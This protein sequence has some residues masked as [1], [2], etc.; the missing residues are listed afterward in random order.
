M[1]YQALLLVIVNRRE[2]GVVIEMLGRIQD[3]IRSVEL[4]E[5]NCLA[6]EEAKSDATG[7][8]LKKLAKRSVGKRAVLKEACVKLTDQLL[9]IFTGEPH[10][11]QDES[12]LV[13][14]AESFS[15]EMEKKVKSSNQQTV[16]GSG[17]GHSYT[18]EMLPISRA[19]FTYFDSECIVR[20][21]A[22]PIEDNKSILVPTLSLSFSN[23][24]TEIKKLSDKL[25][26]YLKEVLGTYSIGVRIG[27]YSR[28]KLGFRSY[29][30]KYSVVSQ[31]FELTDFTT[32]KPLGEFDRLGK[33]LYEIEVDSQ[34]R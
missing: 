25:G 23:T 24:D 3:S 18:D 5:Y 4:A 33:L 29:L 30:A 26:P 8:L 10:W 11:H 13:Y 20:W 16:N 14:I 17:C 15:K 32:K 21:D 22:Q 28:T 1:D 31:L 12:L 34:R 19:I 27:Y 2:K 6:V 9:C 7:D